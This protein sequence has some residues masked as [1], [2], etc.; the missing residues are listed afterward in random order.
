VI[1]VLLVD[2]HVSSR[3][4]LAF[5]LNREPDMTI[6]SQAGT[7]SVA[8][9]VL[10][11]VDVAVIDLG[12]PDGSGIDLIRE[13]RFTRPAARAIV[14]TASLEASDA[15]H[16]LEVGATTVLHKSA[17]FQEIASAIRRAANGN[18]VVPMLAR[19]DP[20]RSPALDWDRERELRRAFQQI[21]PREREVLELLAA[22]LS[23]REI[24]VRLEISVETAHHHVGGLL[25]KVGADSRLQVV[26]LALACGMIEAH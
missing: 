20:I 2:D 21:T 13:L 22:G 9:R 18:G 8:R 16:A 15:V 5:M 7:L 24:A 4:P 14:L 26:V 17:G 1:R 19:P 6:T 10:T 23:D 11:D 3:E 12:L 25:D